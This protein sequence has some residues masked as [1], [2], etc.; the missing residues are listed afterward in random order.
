MPKPPGNE[1]SAL[2][3]EDEKAVEA[4]E[5]PENKLSEGKTSDQKSADGNNL[6]KKNLFYSYSHFFS[7]YISYLDQ[8]IFP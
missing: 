8:A 2:A 4:V 1:I 7:G 6:Q 5:K 3:N